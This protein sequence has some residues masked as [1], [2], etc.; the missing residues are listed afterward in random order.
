MSPFASTEPVQF[1]LGKRIKTVVLKMCCVD[2]KG[3]A[4]SSLGTCGYI[5]LIAV[6]KLTYFL[7]KGMF[8]SKNN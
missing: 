1:L 2:P 4:V 7:I 6:L 5:S 3:S 8:F